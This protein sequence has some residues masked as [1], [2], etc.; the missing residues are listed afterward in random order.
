MK[1]KKIFAFIL[2]SFLLYTAQQ[3][4]YHTLIA[5]EQ[6]SIII[7]EEVTEIWNERY[8]TKGF[9]FGTKPL[10]FL[11]EN[12]DILPKGKAF[13]LAMGEGRNAVYLAQN[14]FQVE[15]CD[16][17]NVAIEKANKLANKKGLNINAYVADLENYKIKSNYYDL[18]TC[19]Y[20]LQRDIIQQIKKGLKLGGMVIFET[21]TI[22]QLTLGPK[23]KC[24]KNR[25]YLLKH[26][27]L[28]DF[29][30]DFRIIYYREIIVD[31]K[32]AI[33]SLIAEKVKD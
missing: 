11:K 27:E 22:D 14:G 6:K 13:V 28:L 32:K 12:I 3:G 33:A 29:F 24:P 8:K 9:I 20:Y 18:I 19:F 23:V 31:S 25:D 21:Y 10:R 7:K 16:I 1:S 30:K 5:N 26:N 2:I 17:S 4:V 15:G